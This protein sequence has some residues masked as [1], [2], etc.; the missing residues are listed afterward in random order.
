MIICGIILY[1]EYQSVCAFVRIGSPTA[2]SPASECAPPAGPKGGGGHSLVGE[3][4]GGA[5]SDD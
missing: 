4:A 3:G 2:R 5:N 1:P